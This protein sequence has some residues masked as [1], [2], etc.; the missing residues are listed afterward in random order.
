MIVIPMAGMSS[1][2]FKAGYTLPKYMLEAQGE[3]LFWHSVKSFD[4]YF[5]SH[6]FLFI[7]KDIFDTP[8]FVEEQAKKLGIKNFYISILNEDTRGQAETVA[9]GLKTLEEQEINYSGSITI[10]NIDTFRKN[11]KFPNLEEKDNG[12]LEV[13]RGSGNNW[14][15]VKPKN[16]YTTIVIET[17]EKKPIS[18]LCC[19]GLYHFANKDDYLLAFTSYLKKPIKEWDKGELYIAPLYNELIAIGLEIH[20]ELINKQDVIFCGIPQEYED[21]K[22]SNFFDF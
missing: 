22:L 12:Y 14:S 4:K 3:T 9:L 17:A 20:Y 11:Y 10:F 18:N 5:S 8:L 13:F 15:Y 2:F 21:F 6:P 1:R 7:V 16:E 19:T